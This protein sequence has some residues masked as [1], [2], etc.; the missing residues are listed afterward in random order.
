MIFKEYMVCMRDGTRLHTRC[1]L[2]EETGRFP[3]IF[4]RTPYDDPAL[5]PER[6]PNSFE[7]QA[8][9]AGYAVVHQSCRG[10]ALSESFF[11]PFKTERSD[12]LDTLEWIRRQPF[13]AGEIYPQGESYCSYVHLAYLGTRQPDIKGAFLFVMPTD[14]YAGMTVNGIFKQDIF[15]PW[16]IQQYHNKQENVRAVMAHYP[17]LTF[18]RPHYAA[19][20]A[21]YEGGCPDYAL[22]QRDEAAWHTPDCGPGE[23]LDAMRNL[24]VPILLME[25]WYD[26]YIGTGSAMWEELPPAVREK[27]ALL[28]GPWP[29]SCRLDPAWPIDLPGGERPEDLT[30]NWFNHL[31][32]GEAL[33][34][35]RE[36]QVKYYT[37]GENAW[38]F[39][40][41]MPCGGQTLTLYLNEDSRLSPEAQ[42]PGERC[43]HYDPADPTPFT[44][45]SNAFGTIPRGVIPDPEPNSRA[46]ILSFVSEPLPQ[47]ITFSGRATFRL[48]VKTDGEDTAFFARLTVLRDGRYLPVQES[49]T[50]LRR[51]APDYTPGSEAIITL[52]S[53]PA[54]WRFAQGERLRVDIASACWPIYA[55][56]GNVTG[57]VSQQSETRVAVNTLITGLSSV[58]LNIE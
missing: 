4:C 16:F 53:D 36:G 55:A 52:T 18:S 9:R 51:E 20:D 28:V 56:H 17:Q 38:H 21:Y 26:I 12:G 5:A 47:D 22:Y 30:L 3:I 27:S 58:S 41:H 15:T 31:R 10:T 43:Y 37:I 8:T 40:D 45:G 25:G 7:E 6:L 32:S 1:A 54:S 13:Y 39:A 48:H 44:G 50:T 23:A 11:V 2:P 29:H 46:D 34:F 24:D 57:P 14:M 19:L 33:S 49:I 35:V 42:T